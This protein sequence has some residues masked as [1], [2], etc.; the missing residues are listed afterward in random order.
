LSDRLE[1]TVDRGAT[2]HAEGSRESLPKSLT[3]SERLDFSGPSF[4]ALRAYD[5]D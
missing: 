3:L 1:A 5:T 2:P 4:A